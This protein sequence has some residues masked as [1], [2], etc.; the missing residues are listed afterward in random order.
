MCVCSQQHRLLQLLSKLDSSLL[1]DTAMI[2]GDDDDG[3]G[4][5]DEDG[6]G[7]GNGDDDGDGNGGNDSVLNEGSPTSKDGGPSTTEGGRSFTRKDGLPSLY[8]DRPSSAEQN[9]DKPLT[10]LA[11]PLSSDEIHDHVVEL[12]ILSNWGDR[13]V[14][15]LT[16][17]SWASIRVMGWTN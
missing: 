10:S 17:V 2:H 4:G 3:D 11:S 14:V 6:D 5:D 13:E 9:S 12:W 1:S 7:D 15:G 16:E 8:T